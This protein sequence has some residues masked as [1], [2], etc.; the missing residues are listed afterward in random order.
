MAEVA[1]RINEV[2]KGNGSADNEIDKEFAELIGEGVNDTEVCTNDKESPLN[3]S[4]SSNGTNERLKWKAKRPSR[5]P[6]KFPL[7]RTYSDSQVSNAPV[8]VLK[9]SRKSRNG[10][11]RGLPK[12]GLLTSSAFKLLKIN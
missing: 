3:G 4:V 10:F 11:G 8:R 9:N 5:G 1:I 6:A 2:V 12:K 7:S